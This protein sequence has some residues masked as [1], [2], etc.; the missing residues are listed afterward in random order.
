MQEGP[1]WLAKCKIMALR[2]VSVFH[3]PSGVKKRQWLKRTPRYPNITQIMSSNRFLGFSNYRLMFKHAQ[4]H[5]LDP[6]FGG[7]NV[8]SW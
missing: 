3:V 1:D 5:N 4:T 6:A 7:S 2:L 8:T